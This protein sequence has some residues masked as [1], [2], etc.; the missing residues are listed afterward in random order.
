MESTNQFLSPQSMLTPGLAGAIAMMITNSVTAQFALAEPL[1]AVVAIIA[2]FVLGLLVWVSDVKP[3]WKRFVYYVA[4]SFIIFNVAVGANTLGQASGNSTFIAL[5]TVIP[6]AYAQS[7]DGWCCLN[8]RV[9]PSTQ[10]ECNKWGG[11]YFSTQ[12]EAKRTC[13]AEESTEE[14]E[15]QKD[16]KF[17]KTWF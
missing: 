17:F 11:R 9:N 16:T 4:N 2:S 8:N 7:A 14:Q 5:T 13:Q 12:E 1:P 15:K 6:T 3:Y 10:E